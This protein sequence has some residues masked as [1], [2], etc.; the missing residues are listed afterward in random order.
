MKP[1]E[2]AP[3]LRPMPEGA[4]MRVWVIYE[5]PTDCPDG[6]VLRAQYA[7]RGGTVVPDTIAWYATSADK[8]RS[9]LPGG[10]VN[11]G[12]QDADDAKILECWI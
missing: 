2:S 5:R 4:I 11:I 1:E 6:Y 7:M 12:R 9:I 8:L 10:V 3:W